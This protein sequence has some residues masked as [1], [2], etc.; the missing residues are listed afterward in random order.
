MFYG[1][2]RLAAAWLAAAFAL[3]AGA[4]EADRLDIHA[5]DYTATSGVVRSSFVAGVGMVDQGEVR[6]V[7]AE[8]EED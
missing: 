7:V 4:E 6:P 5:G 2:S 3:P 1:S 8:V